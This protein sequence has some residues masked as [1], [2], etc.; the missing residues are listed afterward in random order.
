MSS[1]PVG[2]LSWTSIPATGSLRANTLRLA[3]VWFPDALVALP[4]FVLEL[5]V[6]ER[7][8]VATRVEIGQRLIFGDPATIDE[9]LLDRLAGFVLEDDPDGLAQILQRRFGRPLVE[10]LRRVRPA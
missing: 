7:D 8:G 10:H 6:L 9:V 5:D 3:L 2:N 4:A 1:L